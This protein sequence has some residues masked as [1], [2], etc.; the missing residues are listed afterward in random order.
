[1]FDLIASG[2]LILAIQVI[3][4]L[5]VWKLNKKEKENDKWNKT[6]D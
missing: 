3:G 1:M 4:W 2:I 6:R 5:I